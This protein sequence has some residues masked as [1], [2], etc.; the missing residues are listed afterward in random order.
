MT[1]YSSD[2]VLYLN[3]K[4]VS[5]TFELHPEVKSANDL[6]SLPFQK[7]NIVKTLVFECELKTVFITLN[8]FSKIS[9]SKL[10]RSLEISR[11]KIKIMDP[12]KLGLTFGLTPNTIGPVP[13]FD[14]VMYIVDRKTLITD[15]IY[16]GCGELEKTL[17]L[18]PECLVDVFGFV[19]CDVSE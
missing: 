8:L 2:V 12:D 7:D 19:S 18:K 13:V 10:S 4:G 16:C 9:Y 3:E 5:H 1:N 11:S 15:K 17:C 6:D 14:D